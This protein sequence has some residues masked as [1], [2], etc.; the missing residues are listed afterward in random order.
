MVIIIEKSAD[1]KLGFLSTLFVF[2]MSALL[3]VI[4][5]VLGIAN[6][7]TGSQNCSKL[8]DSEYDHFLETIPCI[9]H[10]LHVHLLLVLQNVLRRN[11]TKLLLSKEENKPTITG[12]L[13]KVSCAT[14]LR[15]NGLTHKID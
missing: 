2:F 10:V 3:V 12:W 6:I 7:N 13:V 11:A 14:N 4:T 5:T 15:V 9:T 8:M 1:Y